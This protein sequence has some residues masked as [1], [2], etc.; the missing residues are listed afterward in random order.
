MGDGARRA[1]DIPVLSASDVASIT[2]VA[3]LAG[4]ST[5]TVSRV[6]S[7]A[8]YAVKPATRERVLDAARELDYVQ[9]ALAR[10]LHKRHVPVVGVVVHDITDPYFS[11]VVRGVEDAATPGGYLVI[12][13]SSDRNAERENAVVRLLRSM[14][15]ATLIFAGSG[16]DDPT[17]N[18]EMRKHVAAMR[19]YGA[20]VV[21]LSPHAYGEA[22]VGVDNAA[23]IASVVAELVRLGHRQIA[24]LADQ[25][26]RGPV[27][28]AIAAVWSSV[29]RSTS[30]RSLSS[31]NREGGAGDR[32]AAGRTAPFTAICAKRLL[33]LAHST[34]WPS[35][36][37]VP[38][39]V[40]AMGFDD[41]QTAAM[42]ALGRPRLPLRETGCR[43]FGFAERQ[44]A[45]SAGP[46][47]APDGAVTWSGPAAGDGA[48][49]RH[50]RRRPG[51]RRLM[52]GWLADRVVL[53][54]GSSRGIGAE[55]AL[56]AAA[57]G[58]SVA[59]HYRRSAEA[60]EDVVARV[61]SL[62]V[63]GHAFPA[64]IADGGQAEALVARSSTGSGG[65]TASSTMPDGRWSVRSSR[66]S[67]PNGM[68][69]SPPISRPRSTPAA[70]R[71]PRCSSGATGPSSTSPRGWARWASPRPPRTARPR[72]G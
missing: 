45:E 32:H 18:A 31:F 33:A 44:L 20:A 36:I 19:G 46:G 22:D 43:G 17:I 5:A 27:L 23:G 68:R 8:P 39:D 66:P 35:S 55:V 62:G 53:V 42:A 30:V 41:I 9:N 16:L 64:D 52:T 67:P 54:T 38:D 34:G 60:A 71:C 29:S 70:R 2:D 59:V 48:A 49:A 21:H 13:C 12:A 10:G 65:W 50:G 11:E 61:R 24:F 56:K 58:A 40:T 37:A 26:V 4:V 28:T 72:P 7:A 47:G 69:S 3:R 6:V 14:R 15:A 1:T 51:G 57:E 63:D 25:A